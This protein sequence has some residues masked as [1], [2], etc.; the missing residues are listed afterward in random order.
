M[1]DSKWCFHFVSLIQL[2]THSIDLVYFT[3]ETCWQ[4]QEGHVPGPLPEFVDEGED[5]EE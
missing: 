5:E 1:A 3:R 2:T 4:P